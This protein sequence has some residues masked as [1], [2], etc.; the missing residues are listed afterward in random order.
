MPLKHRHL[1]CWIAAA[2]V[3]AILSAT[4][5][6]PFDQAAWAQARTLR[7]VAPVPPGGTTDILTRLLADQIARRPGVSVVV[8]NRPGAGRSSA[9][10]RL[11]ARRPTATRF[12]STQP[13]F[14][15]PRTFRR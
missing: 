10:K 12:S 13:E 7:L 15:S 5:L 6:S 9:A 3:L 4:L 14:S 2:G 8:E 1:L 11:R